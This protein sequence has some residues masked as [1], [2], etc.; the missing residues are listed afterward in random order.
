MHQ[1][2]ETSL[3]LM[4]YFVYTCSDILLQCTGLLGEVHGYTRQLPF[5][6][7]A[8]LLRQ[9]CK[10]VF[11]DH[12]IYYPAVS[13]QGWCGGRWRI[14]NWLRCL[15]N[16]FERINSEKLMTLLRAVPVHVTD[17]S[18]HC[19]LQSDLQSVTSNLL[20]IRIDAHAFPII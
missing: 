18:C 3:L 17:E 7:G 6:K 11:G 10:A 4:R 15:V 8:G 12:T 9:L 5:R 13:S 2:P 20:P 19:L 16:I 14:L 1:I